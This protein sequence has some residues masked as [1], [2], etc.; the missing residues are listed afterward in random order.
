MFLCRQVSFFQLRVPSLLEDQPIVGP[1]SAQQHY[2]FD[3]LPDHL[4][5]YYRYVSKLIDLLQSMTPK[6]TIYSS[7]AKCMIMENLNYKAEFYDGKSWINSNVLW[8]ARVNEKLF[9]I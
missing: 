4:R 1:T 8:S 6:V 3:N 7:E 9:I 2:R 5:K